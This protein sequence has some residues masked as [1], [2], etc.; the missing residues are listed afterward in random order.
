MESKRQSKFA[1]E[2]MQILTIVMRRTKP[3]SL[4]MTLGGWIA[5]S[6]VAVEKCQVFVEGRRP[7]GLEVVAPVLAV[8][9]FTPAP[10][11]ITINHLRSEIKSCGAMGNCLWKRPGDRKI[12]YLPPTGCSCRL[13]GILWF[14]EVAQ[15]IF[16][17][18]RI[19]LE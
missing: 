17:P 9:N 3:N 8:A 7:S 12:T 13:K 19:L 18:A 14:W 16:R 6:A 5:R 10:H 4:T 1:K 11:E 15:D 2:K